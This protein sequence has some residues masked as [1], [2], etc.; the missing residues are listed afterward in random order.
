VLELHE[1]VTVVIL[2]LMIGGFASVVTLF[3]LAGA[4]FG[5]V[6]CVALTVLL[7]VWWPHTPQHW[8]YP[9][10]LPQWA[11][12]LVREARDSHVFR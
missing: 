10:L 8:V 3:G 7:V 6:F 4:I 12:D 1:L 9:T 2:G 5:A 11:R